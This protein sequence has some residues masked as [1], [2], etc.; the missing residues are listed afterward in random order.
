MKRRNRIARE[1]VRGLKGFLKK[2][3]RGDPIEVTR[4]E[5]FETPDGPMHVHTKTT[6]R[7]R[8]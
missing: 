8:S 1:I 7:D 4:V 2:M 5:R 6:L 3:K